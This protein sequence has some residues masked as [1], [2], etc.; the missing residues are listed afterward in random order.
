MSDFITI[1]IKGLSTR[2]YDSFV[3]HDR[4]SLPYIFNQLG[5]EYYK[6]RRP[7]KEKGLLSDD[8]E[9]FMFVKSN[10]FSLKHDVRLPEYK[11]MAQIK[12][13]KQA[14]TQKALNLFGVAEEMLV[15][16]EVYSL[17]NKEEENMS[18]HNNG[19]LV[20]IRYPIEF[21][22][23][24]FVEIA[25]GRVKELGACSFEHAVHEL[26]LSYTKIMDYMVEEKL[27]HY[28]IADSRHCIIVRDI[29]AHENV[30]S[31]TVDITFELN[32]S[33]FLR[34]VRKI[35]INGSTLKPDIFPE[36]QQSTYC[37]INATKNTTRWHHTRNVPDIKN[38]EFFDQG[39]P[40]IKV[41]FADDTHTTA[42]C[43]EMDVFDFD[44]GLGVCIA[45]RALGS[46]F[47]RLIEKADKI[48][49]RSVEEK[50][51]KATENEERAAREAKKAAKKAEKKARKE[52]EWRKE[53]I[54][55][56]AEAIK[57]AKADSKDGSE[58][59]NKDVFKIASSMIKKA[60]DREDRDKRILE[61]K[62]QGKTY[63]EI[64]DELHVGKSTISRAIRKENNR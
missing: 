50:L 58:V 33:V 49:I 3:L 6:F 42:T 12:V 41:T 19:V 40:T 8:C 2:Y 26:G 21:Q 51:K 52:A 39:R 15:N 56:L 48:Y 55:I 16:A 45:K 62:K 47:N 61:L 1:T 64:A 30:Y 46:N 32:P 27:V 7:L 43:S 24:D 13:N 60:H 54:D 9:K 5:L 29:E 59:T 23:L 14:F 44:T 34:G 22:G 53:Q 17:D 36:E 35:V 63:K 31:N 18:Y 11:L 57:K 4:M 25:I 20:T 38:V 10:D 28:S 37:P